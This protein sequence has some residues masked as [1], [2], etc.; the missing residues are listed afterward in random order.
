MKLKSKRRET[1]FN[2]NLFLCSTNE[3]PGN[4]PN[5]IICFNNTK[6]FSPRKCEIKYNYTSIY[7]LIFLCDTSNGFIKACTTFAIFHRKT[8]V[9]MLMHTML[10]FSF[11]FHGH[12]KDVMFKTHPNSSEAAVC[13]CSST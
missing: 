9:L 1:H 11:H 6:T 13:R 7:Y 2:V 10:S 8:K 5:A 12:S 3:V 4:Y